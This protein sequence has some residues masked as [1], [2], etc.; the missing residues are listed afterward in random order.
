MRLRTMLILIATLVMI[1]PGCREWGCGE[2]QETHDQTSAPAI[3]PSNPAAEQQ[4]TSLPPQPVEASSASAPTPQPAP[5][6]PVMVRQT[7]PEPTVTEEE[8]DDPG[9]KSNLPRQSRRALIL[10]RKLQESGQIPRPN[11]PASTGLQVHHDDHVK[12]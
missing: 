4:A 6:N 12:K 9:F 10:L 8:I 11:V 3:P 2:G 5:T 1:G 7:T